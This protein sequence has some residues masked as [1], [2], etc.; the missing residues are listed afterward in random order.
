MISPF[1][2][3]QVKDRIDVLEI[4][5]NFIQLKKRG[6]NYLGNCPFHNEKSPSFTVSASKG[7]YKCF[8][9]GKAG[10]AITFVQEHE[11]LTY[12]EAIR[13]LAKYYHIELE[14]TK[15]SPE[16]VEQQ[17]VEESLRIINDYATKY[18]TNALLETDEGKNIGLSYFAERGFTKETID[19]FQLG[20]CPEDR[21]K[22]STDAMAQGYNKELL[23]K[24]GLVSNKNDRSYDTYSGRVIFP[25]QNVSGRVIGF[26][27]RILIKND[28]APKYINTPENELYSKSKTLYGLYQSRNAITKAN[29]VYLVEGYTDV[30]S[31]HQSGVQNVV[32]SSGTSL[33]IEQLKLIKRFTK[34]LTII[35]DGDAAGIKAALRGLDMAIEESLNVQLVL[36][37]PSQDPD[38]FVQEVGAAAF[39]EYIEKEKKD[40]ILFKLE[41]SL[42]DANKDSAKK[43][44]L[45]NEIA[46][47]ISKLDKADN[48]TLRQDYTRRCA[49]LL[50]IDE[51]GLIT[52]V[53]KKIKEKLA[54]K[55]DY[56]PE[57]R[58]DIEAEVQV[59]GPDESDQ[60]NAASLL[61]KD[62]VQEKALIRILVE[63]GAKLFDEKI[64]V[65]EYVLY[66][67]TRTCEF[68]HTIWKR[69]FDMYYD[70]WSTTS[71]LPS[72]EYF[73]DNENVEIQTAVIDA[74][75]YPYEV[76]ENWEE[77]FQI[78]VP[79]R[80]D[81]Y[82]NETKSVV[83]YFMIRKLK[84][85][86]ND[87]IE[88]LSTITDD[89]EMN[90][91]MQ[92][93][94]LIKTSEQELLQNNKV[95]LYR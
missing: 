28:K 57:E 35:Y 62:F 70:Y 41:V 76:S 75:Y 93:I 9:C 95:V 4:V 77:N 1:S 34:N 33:T 37:P 85:I 15:A 63:Y 47:T 50:K 79:Q 5:G 13:W 2:I 56:S 66:K 12:P 38:S 90:T 26:G 80:D 88:S 67:V 52:L 86:L 82:I 18:F 48:F 46:E 42:N 20:Y 10:N 19:T 32:A 30:I 64:T 68:E 54:K 91:V 89:E 6:T 69:I 51:A 92:C 53:N 7:I 21:Q 24:A 74:T 59:D 61:Q 25:I 40:I 31:L 16:F 49:S 73:T 3:Q 43:A 65:A 71:Q 94:K 55:K 60:N 45:I 78:I 17:K 27:A 81:L 44:E 36:L 29:E 8:G 87:Y 14:E 84:N 83:L 23:V 22:F 58:A 39:H 11:K 72:L